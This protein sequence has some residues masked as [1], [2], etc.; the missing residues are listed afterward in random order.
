MLT[1]KREEENEECRPAAGFTKYWRFHL[2]LAMGSVYM[3][4]LLTNWGYAHDNS[5]NQSAAASSSREEDMSA[6]QRGV[7]SMW[8][9][10]VSQWAVFLLYI[11]TLVAPGVAPLCCPDREFGPLRDDEE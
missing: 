7:A 8:V 6:V 4:M 9:K 10:I 3:A 11:W 2:I 1:A 5:A